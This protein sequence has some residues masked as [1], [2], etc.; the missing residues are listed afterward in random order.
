MRNFVQNHSQVNKSI[1]LNRL[2]LRNSRPQQTRVGEMK[3]DCAIG[4]QYSGRA[5]HPCRTDI[6]HQWQ[7]LHPSNPS[8]LRMT[9][10]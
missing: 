6:A 5:T 3:E 4:V 10:I 2:Q 9:I 7:S 1:L 8:W